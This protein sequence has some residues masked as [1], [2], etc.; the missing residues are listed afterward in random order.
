MTTLLAEIKKHPAEKL[1]KVGASDG[2]S[3][4]Y[5][6]T[7][8]DFIEN[9]M[10]Y[11]DACRRNAIRRREAAKR[12]FDEHLS[13]DMTPAQFVRR[14]LRDGSKIWPGD[15]ED[16]VRLW[17]KEAE[18]LHNRFDANRIYAENYRCLYQRG[19]VEASEAEEPDTLRVVVT[20]NEVGAFW[21]TTDGFGIGFSKGG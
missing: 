8:G 14:Q 2:T 17:L 7:C 15:Y 20:G 18:A 12:R 10:D 4:F 3:W 5:V 1:L 9:C 21:E 6:G 11:D 16:T 19:V 13:R